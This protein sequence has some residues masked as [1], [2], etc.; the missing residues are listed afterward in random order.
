M[1]Y[2]FLI[3]EQLKIWRD[4]AQTIGFREALKALQEHLRSKKVLKDN[5]II[6][7]RSQ[8]ESLAHL[9]DE[10]IHKAA[11]VTEASVNPLIEVA[12]QFASKYSR[13]I[14]KVDLLY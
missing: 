14:L 5:E 1:L 2:S 4:H 3:H 6:P 13:E 11:D 9:R 12:W 10:I 7:H 8:L